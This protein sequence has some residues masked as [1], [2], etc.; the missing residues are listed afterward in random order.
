MKKLYALME[1]WSKVMEPGN[2]PPVDI[3]PFLKRVPEQL[4]GNWRSRAQDVS[5]EMNKL[6]DEWLQYVIDRR[7]ASGSHDCFLDR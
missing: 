1:N 3:F 7:A 5:N 2:T 4:M 6:Y